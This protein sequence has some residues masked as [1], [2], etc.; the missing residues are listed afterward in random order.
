MELYTDP[1]VVRLWPNFREVEKDFYKRTKI[2]PI[3]HL[4]AIRKHVYDANPWIAKSL[5]KAF[6]DAKNR[7]WKRLATPAR[8]ST[9]CPS[10]MMISMRSIISSAEIHGLNGLEKNRPALEKAVELMHRHAMIGRKPA[11][12]ELF[13][14]VGV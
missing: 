7:A 12:S 1:N 3:M 11:L 2:H 4:V 10:S 9:C 6:N 13:I 14:D 8:R 5:Y